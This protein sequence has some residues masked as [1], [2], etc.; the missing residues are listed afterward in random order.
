MAGDNLVR[1]PAQNPQRLL[2]GLHLAGLID[3]YE[4]VL[5]NKTR[6]TRGAKILSV[7]PLRAWG[8]SLQRIEHPF[9]LRLRVC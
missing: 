3:L 9:G 5:S 6:C 2:Y 8:L 1:P 4:E 7:S